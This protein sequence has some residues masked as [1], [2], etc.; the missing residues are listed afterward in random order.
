MPGPEISP[1]SIFLFCF[2]KT[3]QHLSAFD[4]LPSKK[5]LRKGQMFY[6][7]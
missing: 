1:L 5:Q 6:S 3:T 7:A 2:W 4:H